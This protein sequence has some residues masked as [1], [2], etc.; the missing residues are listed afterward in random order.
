MGT[1]LEEIDTNLMPRAE[2]SQPN[3]WKQVVTGIIKPQAGAILKVEHA[4]VAVSLFSPQPDASHEYLGKEIASILG[5]K[6]KRH[7]GIRKGVCVCAAP[8]ACPS[9]SAARAAP[10]WPGG[11]EIT[12]YGLVPHVENRECPVRV[13]ANYF[14]GK[15]RLG[16]SVIPKHYIIKGHKIV[17]IKL[18]TPPVFLICMYFFPFRAGVR[19]RTVLQL[20]RVRHFVRSNALRSSLGT[21]ATLPQ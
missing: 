18:V 19:T 7:D 9:L 4:V 3:A 1:P 8:S 20:R 5:V 12:L 15:R 11:G 16:F 21:K 2:P 13:P 6:I 17:G 10:A 14:F